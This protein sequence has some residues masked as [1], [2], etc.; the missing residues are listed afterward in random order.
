MSF[1]GRLGRIGRMTVTVTGL[2]S[3]LSGAAEAQQDVSVSLAWDSVSVAA[4]G[5]ALGI[6]LSAAADAEG[7]LL[8]ANM[9]GHL[10]MK[11]D[12]EGSQLWTSGGQGDGPGEYQLLYRVAVALDGRV[13]AL[14]FNRHDLTELSPEGEFIQRVRLPFRFTQIDALAVLD[15]GSICITG[16]TRWTDDP[17]KQSVHVFDADLRH[18]RSFGPVPVA[19]ED[20]ILQRWGAGAASVTKGGDILFTRR[21]PYEVYRFTAGGSLRSKT[22]EL[23]ATDLGPDDAYVRTRDG[24]RTTYST[25]GKDVLRPHAAF[26]TAEGWLLVGRSRGAERHIDLIDPNGRLGASIPMPPDWRSISAIDTD[27]NWIWVKGEQRLAPVYFRVKYQIRNEETK[28]K[29]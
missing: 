3:A 28:E 26:E 11:F 18:L 10:V 16:I 15:D 27:R 12:R 25:S 21:L 4:G 29:S 19:S 5:D 13:F 8:V 2:W 20:W 23:L 24:A 1:G 6:P 9:A 7:N 14:D 17:M 22:P